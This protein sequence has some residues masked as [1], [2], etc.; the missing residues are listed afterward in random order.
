LKGLSNNNF[1]QDANLFNATE[2]RSEIYH[3]LSRGKNNQ[4]G[5]DFNLEYQHSFKKYETQ[6]LML[7]YKQSKNNNQSMADFSLRQQI[8][9]QGIANTT[10][11]DDEF[12]EQA[13]RADYEQPV[14]KQKLELGVSSILY[15]NS[16]NYTYKAQDSLTGILMMDASQSN[17]FYCKENIYAA[18]ASL[19]LQLRKW[20]LKFGARLEQAKL[21]AQLESSTTFPV[22]DYTNLVPT[23][24]LSYSLKGFSIMR[25]SFTQRINRPDMHYFNPYVDL[26]DPFNISYGNP[27][28]QP[29]QALAFNLSYSTSVKKTFLNISLSHQFSNNAIQQFTTLGAD[30]I[31]RTT[32]DNIGKSR[33]TTLSLGGNTTALK[34]VNLNV[35]S[36]ANYIQ[37][38][39]NR[40]DKSYH[41]QG[42]TYNFTGSATFR[43]KNWRVSSNASYNASS[44]TLQVRS[45]GYFSNSFSLNRQFMRHQKATLTIAVNNPFQEYRRTSTEVDDLTFYLLRRSYSTNRSFIMTMNYHFGKTHSSTYDN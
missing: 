33:N 19:H 14:K 27:G 29:A 43:A 6:K 41:N 30:S 28:L 11:S 10:S 21:S 23:V 24:T 25:L 32:F 35:N 34:R 8:N 42:L 20:S 2:G 9:Q 12:W 45:A 3:R 40:R 44:F 1:N 31:T 36:N 4:Y 5:H 22:Q 37:Y 26:T 39:S 16:S 13:F 17:R 7:S 18:Y 38:S 15:K